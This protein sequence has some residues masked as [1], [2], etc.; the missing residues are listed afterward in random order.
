MFRD[1]GLWVSHIYIIYIAMPYLV[2]ILHKSISGRYRPVSVGDGPLAARC[3]FIKNAGL[4]GMT[5]SISLA[6]CIFIP[7]GILNFF[8]GYFENRTSLNPVRGGGGGGGWEYEVG[9]DVYTNTLLF[10]WLLANCP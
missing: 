10:P 1:C 3:R 8:S 7:F 4:V 2:S 9:G 5:V 6:D